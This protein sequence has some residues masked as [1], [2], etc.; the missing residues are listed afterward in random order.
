MNK[1]ITLY[2]TN[3]AYINNLKRELKTFED[4]ITRKKSI[5]TAMSVPLPER[6]EIFQLIL[7]YL[8]KQYSVW[9]SE[10]LNREIEI[11]WYDD[12]YLDRYAELDF[13]DSFIEKVDEKF[14]SVNIDELK[15]EILSLG[16]S[17]FINDW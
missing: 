17:G 5:L 13:D 12:F 11:S 7:P 1:D 8:K 16:C 4:R 9:H 14:P 6:W 2:L 15:E 10:V 3:R